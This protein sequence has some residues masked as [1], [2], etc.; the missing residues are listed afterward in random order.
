VSRGAGAPR[1]AV[2]ATGDSDAQ[3]GPRSLKGVQTRARLLD[4]AKEIFEENGFLEARIADIAV[5]AGLSQLF[6]N[7]LQMKET[8]PRRRA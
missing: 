5:R 2:I 3:G 7:A 6:V 1:I 4:A 8:K